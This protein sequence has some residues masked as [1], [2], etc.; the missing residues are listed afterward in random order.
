MRLASIR[1]I[2]VQDLVKIHNDWLIRLPGG[3]NIVDLVWGNSGV[4][5]L[6]RWVKLDFKFQ[7][8]G[9]NI[10]FRK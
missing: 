4:F 3:N 9:S 8:T 1:G 5:V 7:F 10:M 2:E 6:K